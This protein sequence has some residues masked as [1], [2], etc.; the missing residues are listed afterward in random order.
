[1][2]RS[3]EQVREALQEW[4]IDN[5]PQDTYPWIKSVFDS[6]FVYQYD[7]KLWQRTYSFNNTGAMAV[8]TA[9]EVTESYDPVVKMSEFSLGAP[10]FSGDE[11]LCTGKIFE[12][13]DYPDKGISITEHDLAR[14]AT[15]FRAVQNDIEHIPTILSGKIGHLKSVVARG[16]ELFGTVSIPKWLNE[17]VGGEPI[18]VSLA[19]NRADKTIGGNALV[20]NPRI[21]D[22]VVAAFNA[23]SAPTRI[24][25]TMDILSKIKKAFGLLHGVEALTA[26][27]QTAVFT[28]LAGSPA[29]TTAPDA[30][31]VRLREEL[32]KR[33]EA[34]LKDA[35]KKFANDQV[36]AKK[37]LITEESGIADVYFTLAKADAVGR[38]GSA[39]FSDDGAILEGESVKSFKAMF[40][41]RPEFTVTAEQLKGGNLV[42]MSSS[43]DGKSAID[44]GK[45]FSDRQAAMSGGK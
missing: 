6:T 8:G 41:A 37:A 3:H 20:L 42:V 16:K 30:E 26:E 39:I 34:R 29:T 14:V 10:Q 38:T 5:H 12:A 23:H 28:G 22:A 43:D 31:T 32:R 18:K 25:R 45:I 21:S 40:A 33:D 44:S 36:T 11:V 7:G 9:E 27:E 13:G 17:I 19:W 24:G 15:S 4:L 2:E 1:M 35:A